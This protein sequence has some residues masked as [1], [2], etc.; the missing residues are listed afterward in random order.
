MT[1]DLPKNSRHTCYFGCKVAGPL[2]HFPVPE[3]D[4][5]RFETWK[6][7]LE[8]DAKEKGNTYI[9]NQ[10]R[11]CNKHFENYYVL[12]S[13]RL[14]RNAIPT[15]CIK[16]DDIMSI[17]QSISTENSVDIDT[18]GT[19]LNGF[20]VLMDE[21]AIEITKFD[22]QQIYVP[23]MDDLS[24]ICRICGVINVSLIPLFGEDAQKNELVQKINKY[25]P[26]TV[27]EQDSY[28][29]GICQNCAST[30]L[31]WHELAQCCIKT[32]KELTSKLK[33][34]TQPDKC[35]G[36]QNNVQAGSSS[37][38]THGE[39]RERLTPSCD[40]PNI[41]I[42]SERRVKERDSDET[43]G[44]ASDDDRPLASIA[45]KNAKTD[46]YQ[47]LYAALVNFRN[48]FTTEHDGHTYSDFSDSSTT[49][50]EETGTQ[51]SL[52][53]F[54]DLTHSNMRKDKMDEETR[55]ELSQA[56]TKINGKV[57]FTCA[58]CG[59]NLSSTHTYIFHK[60]IHTGER[61]CVCHIC[62]KQFRTPNGLQRH[63]TETHEKQRRYICVMCHKNFA[64][65]QNLKQHMR[66]HTGERPFVCAHCGK[67]FTQ[68]GSLHVHL[69]THSEHFPHRCAECGAKFRLRA[70][71]ARHRL[72]HTGERPH[73]CA[74]CGKAF[75]QR[76]ELASHALTHSDAK[77]HACAL[78]G[79]A[80]RQR[81][82]LRHHCRRLHEPHA[83]DAA[84]MVYGHAGHYE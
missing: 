80:F 42:F 81:R 66:I 14:T 24:N 43:A 53:S 67:R 39:A 71:L 46:L 34:S 54:D 29:L 5:E 31:N 16:K 9:Y 50:D 3:R 40:V 49:D 28:P 7:V 35:S 65:S 23:A 41:V 12:P 82:A 6:A 77:P 58:T 73:A 78:C 38:A 22:I 4:V 44:G 48:H 17:S 62:G 51:E 15:L 32:E 33:A 64:N 75:R 25:L 30:V 52:N 61:P 63:L 18:C 59:K 36:H 13:N 76:H 57:Y 55:L 11:L 21:A 37:A 68:S 2:H 70:G 45:T 26:I 56:Q 74:L 1:A 10:L 20:Q 47:K 69:K 19:N 83:G 60:R 8:N 72:K 27:C 79:T 84:H